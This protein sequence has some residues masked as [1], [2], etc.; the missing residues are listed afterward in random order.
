V[1]DERGKL[2]AQ[3]SRGPAGPRPAESAADGELLNRFTRERDGGAFAA[4]VRRH[5]PMVWGVCRRVLGHAED[6][7][8]AFQAT[9]LVLARKA[10]ALSRPE[11]LGN[12]LYGVAYRTALK[13]R[14]A[15]SRRHAHERAAA[16]ADIGSPEDRAQ[17]DLWPVLDEELGR[18]PDKYRT[19]L[20]LYY[21]EGLTQ[22]EIAR[23]L[24][25][26]RQTVA[27][28]LAR[29]C[30]RL[31]GRLVRRGV[32]L[33]AAALALALSADALRAAPPV[34]AVQASTNQA[35]AGI[36]PEPVA[37]LTQ[38]VLQE[39]R[40]RKWRIVGVWVL[41]GLFLAAGA[42]VWGYRAL[43]DRPAEKKEA[44]AAKKD[45]IRQTV[46][47]FLAAALAG[48]IEEARQVTGPQVS[49]KQIKEFTR[50]RMQVARLPL[51]IA[52]LE[53]DD[54]KALAVTDKVTITDARGKTE[55]PLLITL[56]K[57][58]QG[59]RVRD[60]DFGKTD[61]RIAAFRKQHPGAKPVP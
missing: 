16:Q 24:G 15:R 8:D 56:D 41:A 20:V 54:T 37:T 2:S 55:G 35:T 34:A 14:T 57:T 18:L 59:W 52:S 19:A 43:A 6:A 31:H 39:M 29:A 51:G 36:V 9:F 33:S 58:D 32:T 7:E 44:E 30:R 45:P 46:E 23:R 10:A 50:G 48:K 60:I 49:D 28:R 26:P 53:A 12:W 5:G 27:T 21:L 13:A 3:S 1:A 47:K 4:L 22:E 42:S 40:R 61:K 11:R 25:C 38:G 17:R